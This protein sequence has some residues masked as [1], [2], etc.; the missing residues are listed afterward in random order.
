MSQF[1]ICLEAFLLFTDKRYPLLIPSFEIIREFFLYHL[2]DA[3]LTDT[4]SVKLNKQ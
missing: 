3:L 4:N 2:K 1:K